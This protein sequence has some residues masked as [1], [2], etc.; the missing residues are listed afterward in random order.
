M[1]NEDAF[2]KVNNYSADIEKYVDEIVE[3]HTKELSAYIN[4]LHRIVAS[5][6]SELT[7]VELAQ[8]IMFLSTGMYSLVNSIEK[9]ALRQSVADIVW[10]DKYNNAYT[11]QVDGTIADRKSKAELIAQD[12]KLIELIYKRAYNKLKLL[13]DSADSCLS[14]I[15]KVMNMRVSEQQ[16]TMKVG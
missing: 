8:T 2:N 14:A 4:N 13:Y 1:V 7:S 3:P 15:K 12:Q 11:N 5:E 6:N 16:L 10:Q 9:S